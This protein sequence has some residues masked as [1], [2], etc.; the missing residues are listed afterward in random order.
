MKLS[1][2]IT[3]YFKV[4][5]SR[6][7]GLRHKRLVRTDD[8]YQGPPVGSLLTRLHKVGGRCNITGK[9]TSRHRGG[10]ERHSYRLIDW[11]RTYPNV[12]VMRIEVDPN[13]SARIA[14][15]KSQETNQ[16]SYILAPHGISPGD[17]LLK[18]ENVQP[19]KGNCL[20]LSNI[21]PGT[22][23]HSIGLRNGESGKIARSAGTYGQMLRTGSR[24]YAQVKMC[25]GEVRFLP[26]GAYATIGSV[27]N[28]LH[29]ME[30]LGTAGAN[31]R[32]GRRPRVRGVAMNA[33]DHPMGGKGGGRAM[34]ST[35]P[36][37]KQTK[38][39]F[40]VKKHLC[41]FIIKPRP[42]RNIRKKQ[43][44]KKTGKFKLDDNEDLN[45]V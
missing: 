45:T 11:D 23:I 22:L 17:I 15:V 35:S 39:V 18:G 14:L 38:G 9:I 16:L 36:W 34:A 29:K 7:P 2:N 41:K 31:R 8:L 37:G 10:G 27:S 28:P 1:E 13:R 21:P 43:Q 26:V 33:C 40:T 12:Q 32:K 3:K 25:S 20:P 5:P 6:T 24:G 30:I 44:V 4:W 19:N 42:T